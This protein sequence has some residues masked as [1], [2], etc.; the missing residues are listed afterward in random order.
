MSAPSARCARK[1]AHQ[2][3][4]KATRIVPLSDGDV[5]LTFSTSGQQVGT[6]ARKRRARTR[7]AL[8]RVTVTAAMPPG[9]VDVELACA[10]AK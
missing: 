9:N 7:G 4:I 8:H 10:R 6:V 3:G 5:Q 2:A 1:L